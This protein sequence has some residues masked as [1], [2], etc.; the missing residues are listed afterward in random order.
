LRNK[1][2]L[3][4]QWRFYV[5]N[6]A[7]IQPIGRWLSLRTQTLTYDQTSTGTLVC[8]LMVSTPVIQVITC[9]TNHLPSPKGW[10]DELAWMNDP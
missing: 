10:K 1:W 3:Q 2:Q 6:T 8:R 7:G 5:T 9:I 4:L